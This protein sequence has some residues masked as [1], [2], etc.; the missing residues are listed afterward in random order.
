MLFTSA[1]LIKTPQEG[2]FL[3]C[4]DEKETSQK[5]IVFKE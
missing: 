1:V 4:L 5:I 2:A 3:G